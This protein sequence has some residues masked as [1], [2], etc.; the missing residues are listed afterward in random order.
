V[1]RFTL[2]IAVV[3]QQVGH[4]NNTVVRNA[5]AQDRRK[6]GE[7]DSGV[8]AQNLLTKLETPP[9][10]EWIDDDWAWLMSSAVTC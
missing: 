10:E 7:V 8:K 2:P 4:F 3:R 9:G 6:I 1:Q 5:T